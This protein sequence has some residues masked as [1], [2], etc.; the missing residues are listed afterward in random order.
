MKRT[1][2][3]LLLVALSFCAAPAFA[4]GIN[5]SWDDCGASGSLNKTFACDSN[6]GIHVLVGSFVTDAYFVSVNGLTASLELM[7]A[8]PAYPDW[9]RMRTGYCRSTSLSASFDF[10]SGPANCFDYWQG[11]AI[12]TASMGDPAGRRALV[13]LQCVLPVLDPRI[14]PIEEGAHV[15]AFK[16]VINNAKTVGPGA[17]AGC[18]D[19]MCIVLNSILIHQTPGTPEGNRFLSNPDLSQVV[20]WQG[21]QWYWNHL[22]PGGN[23]FGDCP[24]PTRARTWGQ[25]KGLY[26]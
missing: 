25:L 5:L 23:C 16:M 19:D 20:A 24:T 8:C 17:C 12:G 3:L 13:T 18:Q 1:R 2:W 11:G 26:R 10:T 4:Q 9:W 22:E 6:T 15:Y 14:G 21:G 7:S